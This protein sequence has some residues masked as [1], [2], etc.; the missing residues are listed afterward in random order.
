MLLQ[1]NVGHAD[2]WS[3][4]S[5]LGT[6][7][8]Q[9]FGEKCQVTFL[10]RDLEGNENVSS[11]HMVYV[12]LNC[13]T[14]H[15]LKPQEMTRISGTDVWHWQTLI[16]SDWHGTYFFIPI[17]VDNLAASHLLKHSGMNTDNETRHRK[18]N[19]RRWWRDILA[20]A[21]ADSFNNFSP[22]HCFWGGNRS[23]LYLPYAKRSKAW[24]AWDA[25]EI[26]QSPP[27][28]KACQSLRTLN[29]TSTL[30]QNSRPIWLFET[31]S[32]NVESSADKPLVLFLDGENW[33]EIMPLFSV[34]Q[35]LP[36]EHC[37][38]P[39][40]YVFIGNVSK[41]QRPAD[42]GCN[43]LFWQAINNELFSKI[44]NWFDGRVSPHQ[45]CVVGQSLGGLAAMFAGLSRPD[46]FNNV[47]CQSGSFWWPVPLLMSQWMNDEHVAKER[48]N[49][50][51]TTQ[52]LTHKV[53]NKSA[54][55]VMQIGSEETRLNALNHHFYQSLVSSGH[56]VT[57]TE[58]RG[59]HDQVCWREGLIKG[60]QEWLKP[61]AKLSQ[62]TRGIP[63]S[64]IN[65]F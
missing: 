21:V 7:L 49:G 34:L 65:N 64:L 30:L 20:L 2:W 42:L 8:V 38:I 16:S 45:H 41:Q 9:Q 15:H 62:E 28:N 50:W 61:K 26:L 46:M 11:T 60:L 12:E 10:W 31:K 1:V 18:E 6:P 63:V 44:D 52:V 51:L 17:T 48:E 59:G 40:I 13:L 43:P 36:D 35:M 25:S 54:N 47:I 22:K 4:I 3:K 57:L 14:D 56:Q 58:Y 32:S 23:L 5:A 39:A 37:L 33:A 27:T 29:W 24:Q 55:I 19:H 53:A